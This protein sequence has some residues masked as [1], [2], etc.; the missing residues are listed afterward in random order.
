MLNIDK[1]WIDSNN[2]A[3]R[4]YISGVELFL[5]FAYLGKL[6][7]DK[8]RCPCRDCSNRYYQD[9]ETVRTHCIVAGFEKWYTNWTSHGEE[10]MNVHLS[11]AQN[12]MSEQEQIHRYANDDITRMVYEGLGIPSR[13]ER[14]PEINGVIQSDET[15][16]KFLKLLKA[17]ETELWEGCEEFTT[18]SLFS[19][20]CT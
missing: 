15:T 1:G 10:Y 3:S 19:S 16:S 18:L 7:E 13:N 11:H 20:S 17:A 9:Q 8:I 5:E 4:E 6:P 2:R 14:P 12:N